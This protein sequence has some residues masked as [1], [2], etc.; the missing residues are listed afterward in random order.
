MPH[1][2]AK[3]RADW[4]VTPLPAVDIQHPYVTRAKKAKANRKK[5][6]LIV[7]YTI[8]DGEYEGT[9]EDVEGFVNSYNLV[10]KGGILMVRLNALSQSNPG[11]DAVAWWEQVDFDNPDTWQDI[12]D[13]VVGVTYAWKNKDGVEPQLMQDKVVA[14]DP[15]YAQQQPEQAPSAPVIPDDTYE[16]TEVGQVFGYVSDG[17][18]DDG[19]EEDTFDGPT[20]YVD[21]RQKQGHHDEKHNHLMDMG[22]NLAEVTL[23]F[24]D[25]IMNPTGEGFRR[26][27]DTKHGL[28]ELAGNVSPSDRKRFVAELDRAREAGYEMLVLVTESTK[29]RGPS[30]IMHWTPEECKSCRM[31]F[32][33]HDRKEFCKKTYGSK[34]LCGDALLKALDLYC[35]QH[36]AQIRFVRDEAEAA[37]GISKWLEGVW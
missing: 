25:Y 7:Y 15:K 3:N 33:P 23:P 9:Y 20:I 36:G 27:V 8:A 10:D 28:G 22:Y 1:I 6:G 21:T 29:M 5:D 26:V 24:G 30:D 16:D 13:K 11:W 12:I 17:P 34:P 14:V 32:S 2:V 35:V 18:Y 37:D 31:C 19:Y 4:R